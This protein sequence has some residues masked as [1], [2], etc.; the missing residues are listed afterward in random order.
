MALSYGLLIGPKLLMLRRGL[1]VPHRT[2]IPLLRL[3]GTRDPTLVLLVCSCFVQISLFY[4]P[5]WVWYVSQVGLR[6]TSMRQGFLFS[7]CFPNASKI[8]DH[9]DWGNLE[10]S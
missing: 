8:L 9:E 4:F 10:F 2:K 3:A 7:P 5:L 1:I 6:N